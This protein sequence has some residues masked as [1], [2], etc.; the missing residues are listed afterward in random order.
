MLQNVNRF[1]VDHKLYFIHFVNL[2]LDDDILNIF[3]RFQSRLT[4]HKRILLGN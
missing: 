1:I 4:I 2:S 3:D